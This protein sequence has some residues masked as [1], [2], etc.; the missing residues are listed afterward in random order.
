MG[1]Y[2]AVPKLPNKERTKIPRHKI[3]EQEANVRNK[4][5]Q[6][7]NLGYTIELAQAEAQR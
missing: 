2:P 3:P 5:F 1:A 6:E 7:V 4:N